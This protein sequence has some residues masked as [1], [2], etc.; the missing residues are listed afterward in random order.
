[1][2]KSICKNIGHSLIKMFCESFKHAIMRLRKQVHYFSN[3]SKPLI[4]I[5]HP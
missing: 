2:Q 5:R 4:K 3:L 1:M